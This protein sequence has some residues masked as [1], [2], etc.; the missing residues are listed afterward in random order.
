MNNRKTATFVITHDFKTP[1]VRS[2]NDPRKPTEIKAKVFRRGEIISGEMQYNNGKPS[3]VLFNGVC[4]VP[5]SVIKAVVTKEIL[6]NSS[7]PGNTDMPGTEDNKKKIVEKNPKIRY[8]DAAIVGAL[9][10]LGAVYLANKKAWITVPN[11]NHYLIGA[12]IGVAGA[13]YFMYR[14]ANSKKVKTQ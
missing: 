12:G 5:L 10:G 3:F 8:A 14:R 13:V 6:S 11:K 1:Y 7:G 4:V 9:I 2:T